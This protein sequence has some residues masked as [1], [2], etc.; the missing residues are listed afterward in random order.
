MRLL[1]ALVAMLAVLAALL[2]RAEEHQ[3]PDHDTVR[4][5]EGQ[6][7]SPV[8]PDALA[9]PSTTPAL[10]PDATTSMQATAILRALRLPPTTRITALKGADPPIGSICGTVAAP[11]RPSARFVYV[12]VSD[13]AALDDQTLE[14]TRLRRRLCGD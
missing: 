6:Q 4:V 1:A 7:R 8:H 14:F 10:P 5:I 3:A 9:V 11:G 13:M 2:L 12:R